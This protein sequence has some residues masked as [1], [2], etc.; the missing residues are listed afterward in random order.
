M[1][2]DRT[3][4]A[5]QSLAI[6]RNSMNDQAQYGIVSKVSYVVD[7][8]ILL[9]GGV[10]WRT[11]EIGHYREIRDLLGGSYYLPATGQYSDFATN[12]ATTRLGLGDK[13]D[14]YNTNTVDWLGFFIQGQYEQGPI[15]A[16]LTYA[17]SVIDYGYRDEFRKDSSGGVYSLKSEGLDGK[18]IKGGL[19][20]EVNEN[21]RVYGNAGWVSKAPIFD[22]AIND[23]TG[24]L[25]NS[26]NEKFKSGEAGIRYETSDERFN[27]S[28]GYY[29][30]QWRNRTVSDVDGQ[31][32]TVTYLRGINSNYSGLE[33]EG[34]FQPNKWVRFDVA[35]SI[36]D[37]VY[38]AD[39]S[40]E[41]V[42]ITTGANL[43]SSGTV[44][45]DDLKIGDA[46]QTQFAFAATVF[47][48]R[49][50]SV[51]VQGLYYNDYYADYN[52]ETRTDPTDRAQA[53]QIPSYTTY[54]LHVNYKLPLDL[55]RYEISLF[56]HVFN[57]TDEVYVSDATDNSRFEGISGAP[58]HSPQRSE[59]FLGRP[60]SYNLGVK[61]KF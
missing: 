58:S 16:F 47:P 55:D 8:S 41:V 26:G 24:V 29:Y 9:T 32:N 5:G 11:A 7:D 31:S 38:T 36:S 27:I 39:V 45:I 28:A 22:G 44:Y 46:P 56:A 23:I 14:S 37:W 34:A 1:R 53:W 60:I 59:A 57:L 4:A 20:Y 40:S 19:Q 15:N 50:L 54:D 52:A 42:D 33:I 17:Y 30:T 43:P 49:G 35:A 6:L 2:G 13:V 18:Q 10:D 25:V 48:T 51:K 3:K 12:G 21:L 61:V